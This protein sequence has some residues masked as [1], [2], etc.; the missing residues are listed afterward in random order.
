MKIGIVGL[1]LIGGSYAKALRP[2]PYVLYG[3]DYNQ[4]T[5]DY[6]KKHNIVDFVSTS[7]ET[8]SECDVIFVCLYPNNVIDFIK[9]NA[10]NFKSGAII[11]DVAGIKSKLYNSLEAYLDDDFE[12]VFGHPVAGREK[13]GITYSDASIFKDANYV[14]TP[15]DKNTEEAVSVIET[16]ASQMGF[17][18]ITKIEDILH[19][20][21]LGYTSQLTHAIAISLINSE[22]YN[23]DTKK[24]IG[25]SY[26]DLTRIAHMNESLWS[27]LF[28]SNKYN[29]VHS[30]D[31]FI[32]ELEAVK[33][34]VLNKDTEL[35]KEYMKKSTKRR[36]EL[37]E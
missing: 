4:E 2:Y 15:H 16:L 29:L 3:Y 32:A 35:L 7:Y 12:I 10:S 6:A 24:F 37:D 1:G 31:K 17:K 36:G 21:I 18:T 13:V 28:V 33:Q 9:K 23:E 22:D 34:A 19:D 30:I 27:E 26:K 5:L 8:I 11:S 20:R 14:L 25:D